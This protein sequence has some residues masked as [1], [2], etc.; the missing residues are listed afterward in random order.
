VWEEF[1]NG[2]AHETRIKVEMVTK[3][4]ATHFITFTRQVQVRAEPQGPN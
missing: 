2:P 4:G 1:W 3:K